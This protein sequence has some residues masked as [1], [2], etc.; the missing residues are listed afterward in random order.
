MTKLEIGRFNM[1]KIGFRFR[2]GRH[3]AE[4]DWPVYCPTAVGQ[5]G[6]GSGMGGGAESSHGYRTYIFG[7][8]GHLWQSYSNGITT[9]TRNTLT[10][11]LDAFSIPSFDGP[12]RTIANLS[13]RTRDR[14]LSNA[15]R[16][17]RPASLRDMSEAQRAMVIRWHD[18]DGEVSCS[19]RVGDIVGLLTD[20]AEVAARREREQTFMRLPDTRRRLQTGEPIL[21]HERDLSGDP[22]AETPA[23][24][25]PRAHV[26]WLAA[27]TNGFQHP[28]PTRTVY[29]EG[30]SRLALDHRRATGS[31]LRGWGGRSPSTIVNGI[32]VTW[33]RTRKRWE[34]QLSTEDAEKITI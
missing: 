23:P 18:P 33:T 11:V 1:Q 16:A 25:A 22:P 7:A 5:V 27:Q 2:S 14:W 15:W 30:I 32:I 28:D 17:T 34:A 19:F 26:V 31:V 4:D 24:R 9:A 6:D 8:D 10:Y 3:E 21:F 20:D 13:M 12:D 29:P